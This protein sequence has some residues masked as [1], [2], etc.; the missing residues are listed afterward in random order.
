MAKKQKEMRLKKKPALGAGL[1]EKLRTGRLSNPRANIFLSQ[2]VTN[3]FE[4]VLTESLTAFS[5]INNCKSSPKIH[6]I[7]LKD[8]VLCVI[9]SNTLQFC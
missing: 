9:N 8:Y 2:L 1:R 6:K 3:F 4:I 7:F 5:L